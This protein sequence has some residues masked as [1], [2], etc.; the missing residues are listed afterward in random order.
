MTF[1]FAI[2]RII[3]NYEAFSFRLHCVGGM[4]GIE[5]LYV[6]GSAIKRGE[7]VHFISDLNDKL[8][9]KVCLSRCNID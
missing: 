2:F 9:L 7:F 1:S 3:I 4:R 8:A 6:E 5:Y